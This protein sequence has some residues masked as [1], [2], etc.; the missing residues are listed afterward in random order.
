MSLSP[1]PTHPQILTIT[2][3]SLL[4]NSGQTLLF[5]RYSISP[6]R[7]GWLPS[8]TPF[9]G[10]TNLF[11]ELQPPELSCSPIA[12]HSEVRLAFSHPSCLEHYLLKSFFLFPFS[13]PFFLF[14]SL[15]SSPVRLLATLTPLGISLSKLPHFLYPIALWLLSCPPQALEATHPPLTPSIMGNLTLVLTFW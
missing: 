14:F 10:S 2:I 12:K 15:W 6:P 5:S 1:S 7:D 4:L 8:A 9:I 13:Y 11:P 3:T